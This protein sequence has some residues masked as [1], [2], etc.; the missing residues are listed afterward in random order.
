M[1]EV[2]NPIPLE[3][4]GAESIEQQ[5]HSHFVLRPVDQV[6]G[7]RIGNRAWLGVIHLHRDG[8]LRRC[9]IFPQLGV[10]AVPIE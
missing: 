5:E 4:L 9:E 6:L 10:G 8:L 2:L 3:R 7:H 1:L